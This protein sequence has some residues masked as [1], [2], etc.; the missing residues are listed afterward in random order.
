MKK[1]LIVA[2]YWPPAGGPGVQR[3][4]KFATYL[5]QFGVEPVLFVPEDPA[6]PILDPELVRQV[7]A[8][9]QVFRGPIWEPYGLAGLFSKSKTQKISSG[10]I[11][12]AKKAGFFEKFA[13]WVRGN[14]F[15]PDARVFWVGPSVSR[16]GRIIR[17]QNIDVVITTGPPHSVHLIGME[18]RRRH[19]IRWI[20][21][22]R[23]PWT[24]IGYHSK[25]MLSAYAQK[26]HKQL[27]EAVLTTADRVIATSPS[28]AAEFKQIGAGNVTVITNGYEPRVQTA[29]GPKFTI[30]HIGSLLS[31]RNP[32]NL[33]QA[34][35]EL[36]NDIPG[37]SE[38]FVLELTG[39][40][41]AEVVG[42]IREAGLENNL[43]LI[44]Y[45]PHEKAVA[46]QQSAQ[47]LLLIEIDSP[48]TRAILP[49]KLFEYMASG[50]PVLAVGP[51]GSDV[52]QIIGE[53]KCG[54]YFHYGDSGKMKNFVRE[55]Y[56]Q[57]KQGNLRSSAVGIEKYTRLSTTR[58]LSELILR[59]WE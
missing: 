47:V 30:A 23:D 39:T 14:L 19:K 9:V 34:L 40:V 51:K 4:L 10:I 27:E 22:F 28:T 20:A 50:R 37:F 57:Y 13:L 36:C 58:Q 38:D 42:S 45:L 24:S 44:P 16:I 11:P 2:Y 48:E 21:D 53:T 52:E 3:W 43:E 18:L 31:G 35:R 8:E 32:L 54:E 59:V 15:I 46:R 25:L 33:W 26:R 56:V 1:V 6:Y 29:A 41:S 12:A 5:P 7:S 55:L 17:E 49:G